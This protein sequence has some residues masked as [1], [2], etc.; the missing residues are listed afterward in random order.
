[1][2]R[3]SGGSEIDIVQE[4]P[5]DLIVQGKARRSYRTWERLGDRIVHGLRWEG[6]RKEVMQSNVPAYD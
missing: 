3:S 5:K 1:M 6:V 2:Y 4:G